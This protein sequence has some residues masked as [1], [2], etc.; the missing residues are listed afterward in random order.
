MI[1]INLSA[2]QCHLQWNRGS[3]GS[4]R[5]QLVLDKSTKF[6]FSC[7]LKHHTLLIIP[8]FFL[9]WG[10][11]LYQ[12]VTNWG[13]SRS[14]LR[15]ISKIYQN[16]SLYLP[17]FSELES[18]PWKQEKKRTFLEGVRV[19]CKGTFAVNSQLFVTDMTSEGKH[20]IGFVCKIQACK[21]FLG[22]SPLSTKTQYPQYPSWGTIFL[23]MFQLS[24]FCKF[25]EIY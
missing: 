9:K 21:K 19:I 16:R 23:F 4:H 8:T 11:F 24:Y 6:V 12:K 1:N 18:T 20:F 2:K 7:V 3:K 13:R 14:K 25:Y 5:F 17:Y 10:T 15:W 22:A